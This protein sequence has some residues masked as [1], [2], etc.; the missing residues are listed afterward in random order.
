MSR[1]TATTARCARPAG[2]AAAPGAALPHAHPVLLAASHAREALHQ[3]AAGPAVQLPGAPGVSRSAPGSCVSRWIWWP[4]WRCSIRSIS[5]S[6]PTRERFPFDYDAS[7]QRELAPYLDQLPRDAA[8]R[9]LPRRRSR[10]HPAVTVDF[11]VDLNRTPG[12]RHPLH[13]PPGAGRADAGAD[14]GEAPPARAAIPPG[15]WCSCCA[16]WGLRRA[17]CPAT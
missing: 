3:L 2:R 12:A 6:S 4:R 13:D 10:A 14:A 1:T 17:S 11:L 9:G 15:C 5:F 8:L 16:I 7:E